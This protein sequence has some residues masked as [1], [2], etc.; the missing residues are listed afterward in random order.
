VPVEA[1]LFPDELGDDLLDEAV[2]EAEPAP[3]DG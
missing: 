3:V 1:V 2:A